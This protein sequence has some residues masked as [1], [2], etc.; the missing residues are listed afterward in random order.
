MPVAFVYPG[1][2]SQ[3]VGMG[4]ELAATFPEARSV[5]EAADDALGFSLSKLCFEGPEDELRLTANTQPAILTVSVAA[6]AVLAMRVPP[7][8]V[9]AGHSLGEF[10]AL[11]C[12]GALTL[13]EAVRAVHERGRFMQEAVPVGRGAMSAV[14]G[15]ASELVEQACRESSQGDELVQ[16]ANFNEPAQTVIS[17][18]AA[19]VERAGARATALGA[20]KV[21][22]LP[23]SAPFHSALMEPV[24]P[25]LS[26][27]LTAITFQRPSVPVVS[28]V[29]AA[30]NH[31]EGR[32]QNLL[33]RQVVSPVRWTESVEAMRGMGVDCFVEVGPGR[34]LSG[35]IKRIDRA[36]RLF[37]VEDPASLEKT[38]TGLT[39]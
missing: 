27:V 7:P 11:C 31:D 18:H 3:F 23:V 13:G 32:L 39:A 2:G 1:Q 24:Q 12:A 15:L 4:R 5:F 16:P 37:Q 10:S 34:V 21:V 38:V 9:A 19:A 35:L 22:P 6:H 20:K 17:G 8:A 26:E 33:V 36:A 29:E 14:L 30:P 25:R 28:N